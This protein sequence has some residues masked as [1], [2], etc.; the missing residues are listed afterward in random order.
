MRVTDSNRIVWRDS[1]PLA[2]AMLNGQCGCLPRSE[3][4]G[5]RWLEWLC[6]Q[7][8]P[9]PVGSLEWNEKSGQMEIRPGKEKPYFDRLYGLKKGCW[10][11]DGTSARLA[12]EEWIQSAIRETDGEDYE[13]QRSLHQGLTLH[14]LAH[15]FREL[16]LS[17]GKPQ[18]RVLGLQL[19]DALDTNLSWMLCDQRRYRVELLWLASHRRAGRLLYRDWLESTLPEMRRRLLDKINEFCRMRAQRRAAVSGAEEF[20]TPSLI[21]MLRVL[22]SLLDGASTAPW[23]LAFL[24]DRL[25]LSAPGAKL[26]VSRLAASSG[27]AV[28]RNPHLMEII[29][30]LYPDF[31]GGNRWLYAEGGL[32]AN[33][34]GLTVRPGE[35]HFT[36]TLPSAWRPPKRASSPYVEQSERLLELYL[37]RRQLDRDTAAHELELSPR[38]ATLLMH[39]MARDGLLQEERRV[40]RPTECICLLTE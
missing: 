26:P 16:G 8:L 22:F 13:L 5:Y 9:E 23:R 10:I 39:R 18:L 14:G 21:E 6:Q 4:D 15:R 19:A 12:P 36:I 37:N 20:S 29:Q 30:R 38:Q 32:F 7:I 3:G 11:P 27:T 34:S 25:E 2:I 33:R 40:F 28:C 24:E 17:L 1:L 35:K 31:G